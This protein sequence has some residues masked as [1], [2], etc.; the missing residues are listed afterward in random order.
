MTVVLSSTVVLLLDDHPR[1]QPPLVYDQFG[2]AL[3][4]FVLHVTLLATTPLMRPATT[5]LMRPATTKVGSKLSRVPTLPDH[6]VL[7]VSATAPI[8]QGMY[9]KRSVVTINHSTVARLPWK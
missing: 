8:H 5:P 9:N 1:E 4:K 7:L 6:L 3:T 2:L